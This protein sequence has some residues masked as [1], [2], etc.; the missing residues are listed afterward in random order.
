MTDP[1]D[2]AARL[3]IDYPEQLDRLT[4]FFRLLWILLSLAVAGLGNALYDPALSAMILDI[5]PPERTAAMLGVKSTAGS[6][7]ST[8]GPALLMLM[9]TGPQV[10]FLAATALVVVLAMASGLALRPPGG[11]RDLGPYPAPQRARP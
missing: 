6:L 2:Y 4:T 3:E 8:L 5:T 7:G 9:T 11:Q 10:G 1:S